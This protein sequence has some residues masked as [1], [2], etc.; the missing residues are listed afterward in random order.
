MKTIKYILTINFILCIAFTI[1]AQGIVVITGN[2]TWTSNQDIDYGIQIEP[3]AVLTIESTVRFA[4]D[5]KL[6]VKRGGKLIIDGG[7]LTNLNSNS[8]WPGIEVWGRS[9]KSQYSSHPNGYLYQ[10]KALKSLLSI[11]Y[12]IHLHNNFLIIFQYSL[13]LK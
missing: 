11:L 8:L 6:I 1:M 13:K 10:G 12:S 9:D 5:A 2:E 7:V 4:P 3:G